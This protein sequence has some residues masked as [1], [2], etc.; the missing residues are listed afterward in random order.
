MVGHRPSRSELHAERDQPAHQRQR[1]RGIT[2]ISGGADGSE[3][4][5]GLIVDNV[6]LTYIGFSWLTLYDVNSVQ[7]ARGPQGTLLGK[8]TTIPTSCRTS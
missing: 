4:D 5:V 3:G 6:F 1:L 7:I 8:N 2:G